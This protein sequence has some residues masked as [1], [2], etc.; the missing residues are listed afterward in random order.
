M[1]IKHLESLSE[2]EKFIY[3]LQSDKSLEFYDRVF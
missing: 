3:E 2:D 1:A